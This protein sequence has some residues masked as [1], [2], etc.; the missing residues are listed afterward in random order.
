[1]GSARKKEGQ[2][3]ESGEGAPIRAIGWLA[4]NAKGL[5]GDTCEGDVSRGRG[6]CLV[7]QRYKY[8]CVKQVTR[9][10]LVVGTRGGTIGAIGIVR[11]LVGRSLRCSMVVRMLGDIFRVS[12]ARVLQ[13]VKGR[14]QCG[15]DKEDKQ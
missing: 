15:L 8:Q 12:G 10:A 11:A 6:E 14:S 5:I 7:A 3:A 2:L 13:A 4:G 9:A 1:M